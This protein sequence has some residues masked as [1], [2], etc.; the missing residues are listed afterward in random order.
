ML[1]CSMRH[2]ESWSKKQDFCLPVDPVQQDEE[3]EEDEEE[4]ATIS[5][6][7]KKKMQDEDHD[8]LTPTVSLY[9]IS[10]EGGLRETT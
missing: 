6:R 4:P 2:D 7:R 8:R 1:S 9:M 5:Q 3:D 10:V